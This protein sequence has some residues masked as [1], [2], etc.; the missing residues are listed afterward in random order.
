[1]KLLARV[2]IACLLLAL[3]VTSAFA[4]TAA[5]A[6][7]VDCPMHAGDAPAHADHHRHHDGHGHAPDCCPS[8]PHACADDGGPGVCGSGVGCHGFVA[9]AL[10]SARA[11]YA[12]PPGHR[13]YLASPERRPPPDVVAPRWRPPALA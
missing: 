10:P 2:L 3:P 13:H 7:D 5:G 12:F 8:A 1:M 9:V 4:G 6:R 11:G